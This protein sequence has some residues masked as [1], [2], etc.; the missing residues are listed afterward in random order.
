MNHFAKAVDN[1]DAAVYSGDG[2]FE[3]E[4]RELLRKHLERWQRALT[5][6]TELAAQV[7]RE[8]A[9]EAKG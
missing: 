5:E 8:E 6:W 2:L 7:D 9:A 4:N 1:L 3:A